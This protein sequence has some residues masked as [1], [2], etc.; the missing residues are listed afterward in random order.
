[1]FPACQPGPE[2]NR[3]TE[4]P[5]TGHTCRYGDCNA[6]RSDEEPVAQQAEPE[7]IIAVSGMGEVPSGCAVEQIQG[8]KEEKP[9]KAPEPGRMVGLAEDEARTATL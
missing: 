4:Q 7:A 5:S 8:E 2:A 6:D 3:K 9:E 1:M